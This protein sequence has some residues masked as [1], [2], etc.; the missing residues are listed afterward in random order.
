MSAAGV[1]LEETAG[2]LV[3]VVRLRAQR[4]SSCSESGL[5]ASGCVLH[6]HRKGGSGSGWSRVSGQIAEDGQSPMP[7]AASSA[8]VVGIVWA[9]LWR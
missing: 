9:S 7:E 6:R 3:C 1:R 4:S 8:A 5:A 2:K